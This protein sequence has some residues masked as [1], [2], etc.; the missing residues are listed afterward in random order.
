MSQIK[1]PE[2]IFS[3]SK[4][5]DDADLNYTDSGRYYDPAMLYDK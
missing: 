4:K 3:E 5:I 2:I 1:D